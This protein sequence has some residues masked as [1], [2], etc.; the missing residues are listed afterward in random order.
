MD[1]DTLKKVTVSAC[2]VI[3]SA[4]FWNATALKEVVLPEAGVSTIGARAF[5]GCAE[6]ESINLGSSSVVMIGKMAFEGCNALTSAVCGK[7]LT[8]WSDDAETSVTHEAGENI[9]TALKGSEVNYWFFD[10]DYTKDQ[11][12]K[13]LST[14]SI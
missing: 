3:A 9:A 11:V 2:S 4:A 13:H 12:K 5:Y 14:V 8:A 7:A 6:L 1:N 10:S